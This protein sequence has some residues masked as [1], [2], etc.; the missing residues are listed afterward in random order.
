MIKAV[1][2]LDIS[3]KNYTL[4]YIKIVRVVHVGW[5]A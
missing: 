2:Y 1:I 3:D 4:Y 5:Q